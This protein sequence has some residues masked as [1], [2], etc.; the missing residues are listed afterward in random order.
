MLGVLSMKIAQIQWFEKIVGIHLRV[1]V[2]R[3]EST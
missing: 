1:M 2:L 3:E